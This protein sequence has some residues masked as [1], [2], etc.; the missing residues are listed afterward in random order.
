[1]YDLSYM[2]NLQK[3]KQGKTTSSWIYRAECW[4]QKRGVEVREM[5]EDKQTSKQIKVPYIKRI[6]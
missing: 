6:Y 5:G 4:L 3:Q 1:M 2:W